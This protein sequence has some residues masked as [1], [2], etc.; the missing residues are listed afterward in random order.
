[1]P[2][3]HPPSPYGLHA[4]DVEPRHSPA[5]VSAPQPEP[6]SHSAA[7]ASLASPLPGYL[8]AF[9]GAQYSLPAMDMY[10]LCVGFLN[11]LLNTSPSVVSGSGLSEGA[12]RSSKG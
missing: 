2:A 12:V 10:F 9:Q 11:E 3:A 8:E 4:A 1:M 7:G 5:R 6:A